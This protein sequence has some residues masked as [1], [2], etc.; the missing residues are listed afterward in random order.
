MYNNVTPGY[1][2]M[3]HHDYQQKNHKSNLLQFI[4]KNRNKSVKITTIDGEIHKGRLD[5]F[6]QESIT[7]EGKHCLLVNSIISFNT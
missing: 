1:T 4:Q 3:T 2:A 7:I 5:S 6:D